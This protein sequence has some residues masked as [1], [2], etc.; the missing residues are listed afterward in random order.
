MKGINVLK[1]KRDEYDEESKAFIDSLDF[2]DKEISE[3]NS[4]KATAG[5]KLMDKKIR[6]EL[7]QRITDLIKDDLK[8]QTLLALLNVADTKSLSKTLADEVARLLPEK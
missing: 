3:I 7:Q 5:W 8:V 1:S 2:V 6:Q 4:M